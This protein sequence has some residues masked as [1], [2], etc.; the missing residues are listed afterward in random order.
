MWGARQRAPHPVPLE[1]R[2][3]IEE[4]YAAFNR[5]DIEAVIERLADDVHWTRQFETIQSQ[6]E[7]CSPTSA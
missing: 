3:D 2:K 7:P 1:Q 5:R 6:V 4:L